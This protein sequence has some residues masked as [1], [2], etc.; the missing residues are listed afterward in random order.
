MN[1]T[2]IFQLLVFLF[3]VMIHEIAHGYAAER[4]GDPTARN[5]GRL[6]LN[7]IKHIDPVGSIF[8]PLILVLSGSPIV[9]GWAKPVPYNPDML[10]NPRT[11]AAKIAAAGPAANLVLAAA[12]GLILRLIPHT[13]YTDPVI[14]QLFAIVIAVNILLA[15]FNLVP[16][17]P[18]DGSKVLFAFLPNTRQGY[19][20]MRTLEQYGF[21]LL[22]VFIFF[23]MRLIMPIIDFLFGML[24]GQTLGF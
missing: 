24:V 6:T 10:K 12:F 8:L 4:L 9:F 2:V 5:E 19:L 22:L 16:I 11:G 18:L 15:V 14:A 21:L 3:S 17:P 23:G 20:I 13:G 1:L 7:P